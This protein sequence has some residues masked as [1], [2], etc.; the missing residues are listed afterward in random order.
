MNI[1]T[2][3]RVSS[4]L[5]IYEREQFELERN[6]PTAREIA[7]AKEDL[8][9]RILSGTQV[10]KVTLA[11]ILDGALNAQG[12]GEV[13]TLADRLSMLLS[14]VGGSRVEAICNLE[15]WARGIVD[16][17]LESQPDMIHDRAMELR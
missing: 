16:T 5:R 17:Y 3:C 10:N 12:S 7:D 13:G 6:Q 1:D 14:A 2:P 15:Q 4:D 11:D 8:A 9:W